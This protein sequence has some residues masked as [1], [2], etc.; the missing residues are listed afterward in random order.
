MVRLER[1]Y[2]STPQVVTLA[3]RIIAGS[4]GQAAKYRLRLTA[5]LPDG[6]AAT[7]T[8]HPD[9]PTE[10]KSVAAAAAALIEGG[11][12]ASGIAVLYRINAQSEVYEAA[13]TAAGVPVRGPRRRAVLRPG[14]GAAG[15]RRAAH[16]RASASRR[17]SRS[18]PTGSAARTAD[19]R[20]LVPT[21]RACWARSA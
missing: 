3:N 6:P 17:R 9:E 1:D 20:R 11:M 21:V 4:T 7:F 19:G 5:V 10:A 14:R 18:G 16:R 13:L 2:R 8:E 15:A 12:P